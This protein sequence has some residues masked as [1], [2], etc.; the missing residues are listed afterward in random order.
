MNLFRLVGAVVAKD[1]RVELRSREILYTMAFFAAVVV[2]ISSFAFVKEQRALRD[3][4]PGVMWGA[5]LFAGT[6]GLGRAFDRER[7]GD[8]MRAL[9]LTPAPRLAVFLGKTVTVATLIL[10]VELIVVPLTLLLF[11][12]DLGAGAAHLVL[13]LVLGAIGF[14]VV[15]TVFAAMLLRVRSR[16]VLL[17]VV[18]YP[19]LIPM[20]MAGTKATA[21]ILG[22][23]EDV[24]FWTQ[25]LTVYDAIFLVVSLWTFEALVIE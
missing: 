24:W 13:V 4:V 14:A 18:L 3:A 2:V 12:L 23:S 9:L 15:G 11:N 22:A 16:D 19:I 1:L 17:P 20:F 7:E 21:A 5:V 10:A 8:T 6:I 25:F